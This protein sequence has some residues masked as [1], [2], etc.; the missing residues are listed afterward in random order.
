[1]KSGIRLFQCATTLAVMFALSQPAQADGG[2]VP[3]PAYVLVASILG[4]NCG[5]CHSWALSPEGIR[6]G[7][8]AGEP[9]QSAIVRMVD[10]GIMPPSGPGL[11][12]EEKTVIYDWIMAGAEIPM[13]SGNSGRLIPSPTALPP[14]SARPVNLHKVSGFLASGF[15]LAA[16]ALGT[17]RLVE[18][19][20]GGHS[21]RDSI[22]FPEDSTDPALLSLR[23][24]EVA[25]L[26]LDPQG[27]TIRWTHVA[28]LATGGAFYLFNAV[29]GIGML[30]PKDSTLTKRDLHRW[31]FFTHLTLMGGE[32]ALGLITSDALR[33]G[34]HELV[35]KLAPVHAVV[36]IAA[37]LAILGSGLVFSLDL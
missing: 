13:E 6:R 30:T 28:L 5:G 35:S 27:Q 21:Y 18:L 33:R 9:D 31:A 19:M 23:Q 7:V 32:V 17:W 1:M 36:G 10:N 20:S 26:W 3:A 37:P 4:N 34:D 16:G 25:L 22:N 24:K 14:S 8:V 15:L 12:D 29:T 11:S 2:S